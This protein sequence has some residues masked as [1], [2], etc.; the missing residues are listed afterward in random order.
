VKRL[1]ILTTALGL[2]MAVLSSGGLAPAQ[3]AA[4]PN[5]SAADNPTQPGSPGT[6][7]VT[8]QGLPSANAANAPT[9]L[10]PRPALAAGIQGLFAASAGWYDERGRHVA[11]LARGYEHNYF[12]GYSPYDPLFP[13]YG[14][15]FRDFF[16]FNLAGVS[17]P[18]CNAWLQVW[19]G[20]GGRPPGGTFSLHEVTTPAANLPLDHAPG[21]PEGLAIYADLGDGPTYGSVRLS[22]SDVNS[23]VIAAPLD[24][25]GVAAVNA[26][27]KGPDKMLTFGGDFPGGG[28]LFRYTTGEADVLLNYVECAQDTTVRFVATPDSELPTAEV[29]PTVFGRINPQ[30]GR[31]YNLTSTVKDNLQTFAVEVDQG[32][33]P[34]PSEKV[35]VS[36][37]SVNGGNIRGANPADG[38]VRPHA[39]LWTD[40]PASG[41]SPGVAPPNADKP[42]GPSAK[43]GSTDTTGIDLA[44]NEDGQAT[45]SWLPPEI[46]GTETIRV[47]LPDHPD[48]TA[49]TTSINVMLG[50]L[51]NMPPDS[52]YRL[53]GSTGVHPSNHWATP[54]TAEG[55]SLAAEDYIAMQQNDTGLQ[56]TLR[57]LKIAGTPD[58]MGIN[59]ISLP[60]GGL[61]DAD[62]SATPW[63]APHGGHRWGNQAD[64][65]TRDLVAN[66]KSALDALNAAGNNPRE[67]DLIAATV[68]P[69]LPSKLP[70]QGLLRLQHTYM[71]SDLISALTSAG[72]AILPEGDHLHVT[73]SGPPPE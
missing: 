3:A 5:A 1:V 62:P 65:Q 6:V 71:F 72:A 37:T 28:A 25:T 2:I 36:E 51:M 41:G 64:I 21:S 66:P 43:G 49:V 12:V 38:P 47:S 16:T 73:F 70:Q 53:V 19:N 68:Q 55:L 18:V 39:W 63:S 48:V 20:Y 29:Q 57:A 61:F 67:V 4:A 30:T 45:F 32:G 23:I 34:V 27:L 26:A 35:H 33:Q 59:D 60:W 44:T 24:D 42:V 15:Q 17:A 14:P 7:A 40:N 58:L 11:Q 31:E 46:A 10:G 56:N 50:G 13:G 54:G 8:P 52:D 69:V 22:D 9:Q